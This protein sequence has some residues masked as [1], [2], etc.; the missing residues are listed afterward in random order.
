MK[1][2]Q[3]FFDVA[4]TLLYKPE[5]RTKMLE[6]LRPQT[7]MD[8]SEIF[9]IHRICREAIQFPDVTSESFYKNF[10]AS[11]LCALGIPPQKD[12]VSL[13][14]QNCKNLD[15][16]AFDDTQILPKLPL[17][18]GIISNWGH[19]LADT[20]SQLL[21]FNFAPLIASSEIGYAKPDPTIFTASFKLCNIPAK[22]V[23]YIGDSIR[24]DIASATKVGF[25]AILLDRDNVF[26]NYRGLKINSLLELPNMIENL[27]P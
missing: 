23:I 25:T 14:Y 7:D 8:D 19:N 12:L 4:D 9:R 21:P 6:V 24:L 3:I 22:N 1:I 2:K 15:W 20:L 18:V 17:P 5:L 13:L 11:F 10:N 16:K 26:P 27:A